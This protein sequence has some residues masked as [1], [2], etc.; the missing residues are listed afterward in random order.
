[1]DEPVMKKYGGM[2]LRYP[3]D[4]DWGVRHGPIDQCNIRVVKS[5]HETAVQNR[6]KH[7]RARFWYYRRLGYAG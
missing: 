4:D 5:M 2:E 1:M 3:E 6:E 7:A